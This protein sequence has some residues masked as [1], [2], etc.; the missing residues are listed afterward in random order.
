MPFLSATDQAYLRER[1]EAELANP[2]RVL[3]FTEPATGLYI[4]GRRACLTCAEAEAL[5]KEV[6]GLSEKIRLE[7]VSVTSAPDLAAEWGVRF[8]PT[9]AVCRE[10]DQGVRF[11]GLPDGY[12]FTSF[13]ETLISASA[14]DGSH[15]TPETLERLATLTSDIDIKTFVTP[16]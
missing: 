16:T 1:F 6:A 8:T 4:P 14:G 12:E 5:L 7:I 13:M 15:L 9:I 3:L 10:S 11:T 2:V